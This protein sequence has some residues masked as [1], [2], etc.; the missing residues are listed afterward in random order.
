MPTKIMFDT[1]KYAKIL[2]GAG[3]IHAEAHSLAMMEAVSQN[4]YSKPEVDK[5]LEATFQKSDKRFDATI[6][7]SDQ[8]FEALERSLAEDRARGDK[9]LLEGKHQI[10]ED[11]ARADK[12]IQEN[13]HRS[14]QKFL[15]LKN[16]FTKSINRTIYTAISVLSMIIVAVGALSTF[17]HT[18]FH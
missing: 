17:A 13:K 9:E 12:E 4:I 5:M 10:A 15:E 8:K 6:R 11:R 14:D 2:A 16:D 1:L 7:R 3:V 18:L